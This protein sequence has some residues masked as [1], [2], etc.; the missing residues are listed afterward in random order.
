MRPFFL[1]GFRTI[2]LV[3]PPLCKPGG[4]MGKENKCFDI[5]VLYRYN[6][7]KSD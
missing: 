4:G 1:S 6:I 2:I 3:F 7:E 5:A